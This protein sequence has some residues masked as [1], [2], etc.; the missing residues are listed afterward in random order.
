MAE[1]LSVGTYPVKTTRIVVRDGAAQ[2][3]VTEK[4]AKD[5][6]FSITL[7]PYV[8]TSKNNKETFKASVGRKSPVQ[9]VFAKS[10]PD[11][12]NFIQ[13]HIND[14]DN[15]REI[16]V[17]FFDEKGAKKERKDLELLN[18]DF[19]GFITIHKT[20]KYRALQ[21]DKTAKKWIPVPTSRRNA[22]G[23]LVEEPLIRES[24]QIVCWGEDPA[25]VEVLLAAEKRRL[26]GINAWIEANEDQDGN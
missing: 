25:E 4:G 7:S 20:R 11:L 1:E 14:K 18:A 26:T 9:N 8:E 13:K 17:V 19:T 15:T 24:I 21:F 6:M 5:L 16:P 23:V 2:E 12:F 10:Q 3:T 22:D